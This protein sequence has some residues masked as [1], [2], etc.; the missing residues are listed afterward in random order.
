MKPQVKQA[1]SK[2]F[3][4]TQL[5]LPTACVNDSPNVKVHELVR[6]LVK[7]IVPGMDF[8]NDADQW[9]TDL[10]LDTKGLHCCVLCW[11]LLCTTESVSQEVS[12][13]PEQFVNPF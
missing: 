10:L 6:S 12:K 13:L 3:N 11:F 2:T 5:N 4:Y 8:S 7:F 9:I 1:K